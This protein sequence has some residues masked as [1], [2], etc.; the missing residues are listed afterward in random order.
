M[1]EHDVPAADLPQSPFTGGFAARPYPVLGEFRS[2]C[3]VAQVSTAAGRRVWMIT[4]PEQVRAGFLDSRLVLRR[5]PQRP[6]DQGPGDQGPGARPARAIDA[7]L[8]NQGPEYHARV[9]RLAAGA[10]TPR[11]VEAYRARIETAAANLVDRLATTAHAPDSSGTWDSSGTPGTWDSPDS[12]VGAGEIDLMESFARPLPFV[13]LCEVFGVPAAERPALH[14][15]MSVPFDQAGRNPAALAAAADGLDRYVRVLVR[16]RRAEPGDDLVSAIVRTWT[17][18][19]SDDAAGAAATTGTS[20]STSTATE[21]D[22]SGEDEVVSLCAMLLL[23]GFDSTVQ[24][25]GMC[26][27]GLLTQPDAARRLRTD[28]SAMRT[29][30]DEFLR[31]DTPGPFA[32]PRLAAADLRIGGTVIPAGS[33]VLLAI[34][35]ANHDPGRFPDP[36]VIDLDR[37]SA[38][39]GGDSARVQHLSFGLGEHYCLGASLAK[40]ELEVAL[41]ALLRRFPDLRLAVAPSQLP[42]RGNHTYRRL[43]RLP[44]RLS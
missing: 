39:A 32:T 20:T 30:I 41:T 42:W 11:R 19:G 8:M 3:P 21:K 16:R 27:L 10:L 17:A 5:A 36:E 15:W 38:A 26:V 34:A 40:L 43:L 37:Q 18:S 31:W 7:T 33:T 2:R 29:A 12:P 13:V 9:K 24:M 23:A 6:D 28:P 22:G 35:A 1:P 4:D 44:L 25:I 14:E